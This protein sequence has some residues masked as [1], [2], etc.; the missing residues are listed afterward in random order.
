MKANEGNVKQNL[1]DF[2][3]NIPTDTVIVLVGL[4]QVKYYAGTEDPAGFVIDLLLKKFKNIIV[5]TFTTSVKKTKYFDLQNTPSDYG[6]FANIFLKIAEYRT[7]SPFKSCAVKGP[8]VSKIQQLQFENDFASNGIFEFIY[9]NNISTINFGTVDIRPGLIHYAEYVKKV[10]YLKIEKEKI[11]VRNS[12]G[13]IEDKVFT[14]VSQKINY[15]FN[16][17]K[18]EQDLI[19]NSL[20]QSQIF[21]GICMRYIPAEG[22]YHFFLERISKDP[23]YLVK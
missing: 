23:Y 4:K 14:Q 3:N 22:H 1:S 13:E 18:I 2:I 11:K 5:P 9:K 12:N 20:I 15:K 6:A 17:A 21:N 10:P 16:R 7:P 8:I 19:Q